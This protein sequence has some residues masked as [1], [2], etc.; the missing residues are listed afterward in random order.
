MKKKII[1][2]L[3]PWTQLALWILVLLL[4]ADR[5]RPPSAIS[6]AHAQD[7]AGSAVISVNLAQIGGTKVDP[8]AGLPVRQVGP[9][10]TSRVGAGN[11]PFQK[12]QE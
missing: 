10:P 4:V 11:F 2:R 3:D 8:V 6:S 12:V 9:P 7:S 1:L 5:I